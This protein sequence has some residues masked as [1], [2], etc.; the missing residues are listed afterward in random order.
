MHTLNVVL[1]DGEQEWRC[2]P[3]ENYPK[4]EALAIKRGVGRADMKG[5][6]VP[7][8]SVCL[9]EGI[10]MWTEVQRRGDVFVVPPRFLHTVEVIK[11]DKVTLCL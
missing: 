2:I 9:N 11:C 10:P 3:V 4:L 8:T 5:F 6:F 7:T 1:S